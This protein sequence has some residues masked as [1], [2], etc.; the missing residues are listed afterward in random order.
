MHHQDGLV[1]LPQLHEDVDDGLF[2]GSVHAGKRFIHQIDLRILRQRPRQKH[3][4]LLTAGELTDLPVG[5][6]PHPYFV[7]CLFC[8]PPIFTARAFDPTEPSVAPHGHHFQRA[9]RKVPTHRLALR[10]ISDNAPHLRIRLA[11]DPHPT[12]RLGHQVHDRRNHRAFTG[13][14]GSDDAYK[15]ALRHIQIHIPQHRLA[16]IGDGHIMDLNRNARRIHTVEQLHR[17]G[18]CHS[19]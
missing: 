8:H 1:L 13:A 19:T 3:T 10:H 7:E 12:R 15:L 17:G 18:A 16:V 11:V 2:R 5:I 4:L 14:I 9:D 6:F